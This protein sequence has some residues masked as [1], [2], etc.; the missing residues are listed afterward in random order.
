MSIQNTL[1]FGVFA[2]LVTCVYL[3]VNTEGRQCTVKIIDEKMGPSSSLESKCQYN[4]ETVRTLI[5]GPY[6]GL[7]QEDKIELATC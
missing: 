2:G 5:R 1:I 4:L 3:S 6:P 7:F